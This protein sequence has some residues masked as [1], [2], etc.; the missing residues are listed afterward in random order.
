M[1]LS[2][3]YWARPDQI[4]YAASWADAAAAG[5]DDEFIAEELARPVDERK[6]P[7][8]R[9]LQEESLLPFEEWARNK[10]RTEY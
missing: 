3:I 10:D 5:F 8:S 4:F 9:I 6:I 7:V 1:C 2:A